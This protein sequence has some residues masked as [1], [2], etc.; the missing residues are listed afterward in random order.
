MD[1][2]NHGIET[3]S[4]DLIDKQFLGTVEDSRD[5]NKDG[6]CR[7]RIFGIH[8]E[9]VPVEDLPW[10][11]PRQKSLYFGK[12]GKAGAISIPKDGSVVSVR[13]DNGNI[14][15]PE[16][17]SVQELADDIK[18]ELSKDNEY[19]GSHFLLFDG[20]EELKIWFTK[21]KGMTMQ[22]KG[23]RVN[24][25]QDKTI[26]I[27]HDTTQSIITLKGAEID[28]TADS[29]ITAT[30]TSKIELISNNIHIN[31]NSV[32]VGPNV[33]KGQP[34]VLGTSLTTALTTLANAVDAKWPPTPGTTFSSISSLSQTYLSKTTKITP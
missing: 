29:K 21:E 2:L 12:D 28:I 27:E 15:S 32:I 5:P 14:Y 1:N 6:R 22:L 20:D 3:R 26:S 16:Y 13:F 24:I 25:G 23:S 17:Y 4:S 10:A 11:Y 8:G 19:H 9:S 31:G 33:D 18:D 7:L 30:S 34:G